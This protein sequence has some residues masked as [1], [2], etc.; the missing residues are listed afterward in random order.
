M[1]KLIGV[2]NAGAAASAP[3]LSPAAAR[4][5][6]G[7]VIFFVVAAFLLLVSMWARAHAAQQPVDETTNGARAAAVQ[8]V[9]ASANVGFRLRHA[10]LAWTL[11]GRAGA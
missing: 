7:W 9:N 2:R 5:A 10:F 8:P 11:Q 3:E 4:F 1:S 6:R